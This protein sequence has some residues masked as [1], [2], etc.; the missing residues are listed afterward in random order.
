MHGIHYRKTSNYRKTFKFF[1]IYQHVFKNLFNKQNNLIA[2]NET[3]VFFP[4]K[5]AGNE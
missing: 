2:K 1:S 4:L 5:H 3:I